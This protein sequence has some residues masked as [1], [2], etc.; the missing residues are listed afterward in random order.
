[1]GHSLFFGLGGYSFAVLVTRANLNW[2]PSLLLSGLVGATVA[3]VI[4]YIL[5]SRKMR[6]GYFAMITLGLNEV[7]RVLVTNS[8]TLQ[9]STG[10]TLPPIPS[11]AFGYYVVLA[12]T[13]GC[14]ITAYIIDKTTFGL[15]LKA[16]LQDEDVADC[17]AINTATFKISAMMLS[18]FFPSLIGAVTAWSWSY[19]EPRMAFDLMLSFQ[20]L[21]MAVFGGLGTFWGPILGAAFLTALTELLW[22]N[23]PNFSAIIFGLLV[24]LVVVLEPGGLVNFLLRFKKRGGTSSVSS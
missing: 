9:G 23:I 6:I 24:I 13:F 12:I 16:I 11:A 21:I 19:L 15:G 18:A 22:T 1:M 8:D 2:L 17:M 3:L 7:V 5:L 20:I 10:I 14:E 4:G